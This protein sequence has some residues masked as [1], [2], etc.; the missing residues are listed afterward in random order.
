MKHN[1]L[2]PFLEESNNCGNQCKVCGIRKKQYYD[3]IRDRM[4]ENYNEKR[5]QSRKYQSDYKKKYRGKINEPER[6]R[7]H[8]DVDTHLNQNTRSRAHHA[9]KGESNHIRD[10]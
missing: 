1:Y 5:I 7:R 9:L 4:N 3:E 10:I 6:K 8:T 2:L